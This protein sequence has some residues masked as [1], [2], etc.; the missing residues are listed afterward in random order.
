KGV[1]G[2]PGRAFPAAED[3]L[4]M[5]QL[6]L[7]KGFKVEIYASGIPNARSLRLGDK[8]TVFVSNRVLDKVY[9]IVDRG[10]KRETKV[11]ASGLDRPNGLAF[12]NGTLYIDAGT[13]ISKLEK[14]EDNLEEP[15]KLGVIYNDLHNPHSHG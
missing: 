4:P 6:K 13:Q 10:G 5:P 15:P 11:I 12:H 2:V 7:P 3:K 8:G 14:I 1:G 9:A